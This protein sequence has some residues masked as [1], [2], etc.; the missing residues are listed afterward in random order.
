MSAWTRKRLNHNERIR[1]IFSFIFDD[2]HKSL[3]SFFCI[4]LVSLTTNDCKH[5][6]ID[7]ANM[8]EC[9]SCAAIWLCRFKLNTILNAC[10]WYVCSHSIFI[11]YDCR[12]GGVEMF[13]CPVCTLFRLQAPQMNERRR[14]YRNVI[15][16]HS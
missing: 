1:I 3:L 5:T 12:W 4:L 14:K 13:L 9:S 6:Q 7:W 15:Q 16:M 8:C 10:R 2:V 11:L